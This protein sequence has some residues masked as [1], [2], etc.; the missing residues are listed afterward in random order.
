MWVKLQLESNCC[1]K[2]Q[3]VL[4]TN[5]QNKSY[6]QQKQTKNCISFISRLW[7]TNYKKEK[8]NCNDFLMY[9]VIQPSLAFHVERK[10][11]CLSSTN[12]KQLRDCTISL[13]A[14]IDYQVAPA[15]QIPYP[16]HFEQGDLYGFSLMAALKHACNLLFTLQNS[17]PQGE[18]APESNSCESC[19]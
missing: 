4:K 8:P 17:C 1:T 12:R 16:N 6:H 13:P 14:Q 10:G 15:S 11:L 9:N 5:K 2:S 19:T 3:Q 18:Q 7:C